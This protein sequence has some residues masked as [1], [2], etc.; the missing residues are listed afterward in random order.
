MSC[1]YCKGTGRRLTRNFGTG[2]DHTIKCHCK[3]KLPLPFVVQ[4]FK[5]ACGIAALA[6]VSKKTFEEVR[7]LFD[8]SHDWRT[9]GMNRY[10]IE[11]MFE[12]LGFS[13]QDRYKGQQRLGYTE[14]AE[15]PGKPFAP[16]HIALVQNLPN[17]GGHF[18]VWL[19]D[20]RVMDPWWGVIPS[21]DNYT[22]VDNIWGL[23]KIP[24][25]KEK[26]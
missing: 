2:E 19:A 10:E 7:V 26:K 17:T 8:L 12:P 20:G 21:L 22:R 23:W 15:W 5:M 16:V 11:A 24:K 13:Y 1:E 4:P 6:M 14:R 9:E 3:F 18:V 25:P